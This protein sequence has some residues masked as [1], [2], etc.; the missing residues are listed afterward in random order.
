MGIVITNVTLSKQT[1]KVKESFKVS[2]AVKE[3]VAEPKM[4]RLPF[5]LGEPKGTLGG[6]VVTR[7][8]SIPPTI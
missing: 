2:V 6:T 7:T 1:V 8:D 5:R 4:Y 3:T